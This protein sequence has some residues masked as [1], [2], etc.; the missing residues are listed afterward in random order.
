M[1]SIFRITIRG[2]RDTAL[3]FRTAIRRARLTP[4]QT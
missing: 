2:G 4:L 1:P 3:I